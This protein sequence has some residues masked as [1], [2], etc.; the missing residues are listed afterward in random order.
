MTAPATRK[1]L[2]TRAAIDTGVALVLAMLAYPFP[3]ARASLP[4]PVFV[5]S[6]I[7]VW[8]VVQVAYCAVTAGIWHGTA[9]TRLAGLVVADSDGGTGTGPRRAAWGALAGLSATVQAI[10]PPAD[11]SAGMAAR[12]TGIALVGE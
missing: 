1:A 12:A 9:G 4:L 10:V 3:I 5:G 6:V 8:Q 11:G 2:R 7:L